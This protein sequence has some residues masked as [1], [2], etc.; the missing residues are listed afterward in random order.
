MRVFP[1]VWAGILLV[2]A[3][4]A[5][6]RPV[7]F[8]GARLIPISG[9]EI[10]SGVLVV[11]RGKIV[12]AGPAAAVTIPANAERRDAS[13]KTIMPG[14]VDTHSHIGGVD[15]GDSSASLHPGVRVIDSINVRDTRLRKALSGGITTVNIMPGSGLLL[16]GQTVYLKLRNGKVIDDFFI[17]WPDGTPMGGMKMANGTNPRGAPPRPG[18]RAKAAAMARALFIKA[19]EYRAKV[20][21]AGGDR[22]KL[23]PR[24]LDMEGLVEVLD[25]KR[26]VHFHTHRH[27]DILTVLRLAKEFGFKLVLQHASD[28]WAV[29]NEIAAA[30]L[31]RFERYNPQ[32]QPKLIWPPAFVVVRSYLDQLVRNG[33]LAA[34]QTAAISSALDIAEMRSGAARASALN[35]LA[36]Q[37]DKDA[38]GAKDA[39]RVRTMADEIR[40]LAAASK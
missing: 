25:G 9:P 33:G 29:A 27:D 8:T 7:A 30:K 10:A 38:G 16:S 24:D 32:S 4:S 23:P 13:G 14:F 35:E 3:A 19:Q 20:R 28:G 17:P 6:D 18:T 26:T 36:R 2:L 12:A 22:S 21:A 1:R 31:V 5:Q 40:R 15:G 39:A 11:E 37:V 34:E